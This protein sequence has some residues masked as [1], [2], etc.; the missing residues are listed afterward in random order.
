[1]E[2]F[3]KGDIVVL[4]FPFSDLSNSKRRPAL[5]SAS[6][7]SEEVILCQITS[8]AKVDDYSIILANDDF[9]QGSLNLTSMIRPNKLFTADMSII[10]YKIG[11]LKELK[12][13]EVEKTIIEIFRK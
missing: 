10:I 8:E 9:K 6:L 2:K 3:V 1:M 12:I 13:K 5:V 11:S 7:D 4:P